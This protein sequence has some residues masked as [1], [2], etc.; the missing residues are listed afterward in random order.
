MIS[1]LFKYDLFKKILSTVE[2]E[3]GPTLVGKL[4]IAL[5]NLIIQ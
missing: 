2:K 1:K 4:P 3:F 5:L